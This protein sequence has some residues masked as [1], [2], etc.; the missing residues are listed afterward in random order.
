MKLHIV[1]LA[2]VPY[3]VAA[4]LAEQQALRLGKSNLIKE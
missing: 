4:N 2:L 3:L 1:V